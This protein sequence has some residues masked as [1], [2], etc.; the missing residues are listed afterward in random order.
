MSFFDRAIENM[1]NEKV[2]R[3]KR[4]RVIVFVSLITLL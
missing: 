2:S 1:I 4:R 3:A